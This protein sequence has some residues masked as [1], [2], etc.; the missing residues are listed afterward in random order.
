MPDVVGAP[1]RG[2]RLLRGFVGVERALV[3]GPHALVEVVPAELVVE[4]LQLLAEHGDILVRR[5]GDRRELHFVDPAS[6]SATA[7]LGRPHLAHHDD[8]R[9]H[10][11]CDDDPLHGDHPLPL[12]TS[13]R[14]SA[15]ITR[16]RHVRQPTAAIPSGRRE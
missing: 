10:D 3:V 4:A 14:G 1:D 8:D 11:Q 6:A 5:P 12:L 2:Q 13:L 16:L 9:D 15:G 7:C